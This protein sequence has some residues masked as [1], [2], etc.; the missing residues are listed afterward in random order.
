MECVDL[1]CF[2][3]TGGTRRIGELV[4]GGLARET[5]WHDLMKKEI[6]Q[7]KSEIVVVAAPVYGGRIPAVAAKRLRELSGA[8]KYA[9]TLAVYGTRAYEDALLELNDAVKEAGF[10]VLASGAFVAQHSLAPEIGAGRPDEADEAQLR[11][12]ARKALEK[13][14]RGGQ[15]VQVPGSR[16]YKAGLN[17][18]V[19]PVSTSACVLCGNCERVCPVG[20]IQIREKKLLTDAKTCILCVACTKVCAKQARILPEN[21][22][23]QNAKKLEGLRGLRRENE[24]FL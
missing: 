4:A 6:G 24:I 7:P 5:V 15:E 19:T 3:P 20:A 16:P 2:S 12:F 23:A 9:V 8:G 10:S 21:F 14:E 11:E 22:C 17:L 1:Y 13:I 18:P